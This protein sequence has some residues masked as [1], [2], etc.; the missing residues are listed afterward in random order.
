MFFPGVA[1]CDSSRAG[2]EMK[3]RLRNLQACQMLFFDVVNCLGGAGFCSG[4][5]ASKAVASV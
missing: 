1:G 5:C 3:V 4:F 2:V